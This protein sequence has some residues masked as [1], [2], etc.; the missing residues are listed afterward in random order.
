MIGNFFVNDYFLY[1]YN[2]FIDYQICTKS[3]L[4]D[5]VLHL[6]SPKILESNVDKLLLSNNNFISS[7]NEFLK[8]QN[9]H[10]KF[11]KKNKTYT[12]VEDMIDVKK[13]KNK[14]SKRNKKIVAIEDKQ[15]LIQRNSVLLNEEA[16]NLEV[17]K[18]PK[19]KKK[20]KLKDDNKS[21]IIITNINNSEINQVIINKPL[22]IQELSIKLKIPAPEIIT[23]LFLKGISVTMNQVV[24]IDIA[25]DIALNY[26]VEVINNQKLEEENVSFSNIEDSSALT[27]Q[28]PP[29]ITILGHV[30]HG[31]TTLLDSILKTN[32]VGQEHGG[33]TQSITG[34]EIEWLYKEK[35]Y[36]LVFIDTPGHD[37]FISMRSRGVQITDI[38][39]LIVAADDG[40]KPQTIESINHIFAKQLPYIV[41][42]NKIDKS[43]INILKIKEELAQYNILDKEW[44][45]DACII[46]V[47][48]LLNQ[49]IDKLLSKLCELS[50]SQALKA[51]INKLAEGLIL[52]TYLK[53]Q[54]GIVANLVIQSGI[55]KV[56]DYIVSGGIYGRIKN[57]LNYSNQSIKQAHPSSI[58]QVLGF[59]SMPIAGNSFEVVAN[60]KIARV[61]TLHNINKEN[62]VF[63]SLD[64]LN[65]RVTLDTNDTTHKLKQL[66]LILRTDT[67]GSLEAILNAFARIPQSK[68]QLNV[69]NASSG[70]ISNNDID[71]AHTSNALILSF[72][73][74][75]S[76]SIKQKSKKL[77]VL[78]Q[79]FNIIYDLLSYVQDS[80]LYLIEPEFDKVFLGSA[81]VQT[82][83]NVNKK[84]IAGCLVNKGKLIKNAHIHVYRNNEMIYTCL[85]DSLKRM[86]DDVTEVNVDTECGVMCNDYDMWKQN[87]IINAYN[88]IEK[89]KIL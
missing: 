29:I 43:D 39:L 1:S 20:N 44:G 69:L 23:F 28:R 85:L 87:D 71:L 33:I 74:S 51:N 54:T 55:L 61:C 76:G 40:L 73:M 67:Q 79:D 72:N 41:V 36:K 11:D 82:V 17:V 89:K 21:E 3:M 4:F 65:R 14:L 80:M 2:H 62:T 84:T 63:S 58:V 10:N 7:G 64:L 16:L 88:L 24:D 59:S 30:D 45:G 32:L 42:I 25:K 34:Y 56:G 86:K 70:N 66:N 46:E 6:I 77:E 31:K 57:L 83:F 47:S 18:T 60:E 52:E 27:F 81:I 5:N 37:A 49:N 13:N 53:K 68:V 78:I 26:K 12:K 48:A 9:L 50:I 15:R 35:E 75:I 22:A 8:T 38:A 19:L